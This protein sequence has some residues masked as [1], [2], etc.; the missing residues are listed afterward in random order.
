MMFHRA[1]EM[2]EAGTLDDARLGDLIQQ[3]EMTS[4]K[5]SENPSTVLNGYVLMERLVLGGES[6]LTYA[7]LFDAGWNALAHALKDK[8]PPPGI[9]KARSEQQGSP[10]SPPPPKKGTGAQGGGKAGPKTTVPRPARKAKPGQDADIAEE[11]PAP[12]GQPNFFS[13]SQ[14]AEVVAAV[15]AGNI[16]RSDA[17]VPPDTAEQPSRT[18]SKLDAVLKAVLAQRQQ[19]TAYIESVAANERLSRERDAVTRERDALKHDVRLFVTFASQMVEYSHEDSTKY[20]ASTIRTHVTL[21]HESLC[22]DTVTLWLRLAA[23]W[24]D[25]PALQRA[26][27]PFE[28]S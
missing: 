8:K 15:S 20:T 28:P 23:A 22:P 5:I 11:A 4:S 13:S 18:D 14:V 9:S 27:A 16:H 7:R 2:L 25:Q 12:P 10:Q 24:V 3:M 19:D 6:E 17:R 26:A 21:Q 1:Y